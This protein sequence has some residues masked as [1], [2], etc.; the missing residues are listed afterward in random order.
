MKHEE[1]EVSVEAN[2]KHSRGPELL[3]RASNPLI[4]RGAYKAAVALYPNRRIVL[5]HGTRV[6][7]ESA[8]RDA[9]T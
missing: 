7:E 8:R 5:R 9:S 6:I 4:G 3:A 2:D 1:L